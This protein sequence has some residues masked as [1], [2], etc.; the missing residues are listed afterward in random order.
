MSLAKVVPNGLKPQVCKR[1]CLRKP[2][3]VP[4]LPGKDKVQEE[5]S[6][7]KNLQLKM[8]I[9]KDTTLNSSVVRQRDQESHVDACDGNLGCDQEM[10]SF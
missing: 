10:W 2:P 5:V 7:M 1:L 9:D 3:P 6:K 8:L 4:Y